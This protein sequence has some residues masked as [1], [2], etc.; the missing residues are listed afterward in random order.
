MTR[1]V[2]R[3]GRRIAE[4]LASEVE[5]H[6]D[7]PLDRLA[8][9]DADRD[10]EASPHGTFAYEVTRDGDP[11]GEVYLHEDRIRL[12]LW[13]RL[14]AARAAAEEAGLRTRP[15]AVDPPRLVVFVENG[16]EVKRTLPVL[17]AVAAGNRF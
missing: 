6:E 14:D 3:D 15:K 2:L 13:T 8:V 5:G 9:G 16:A 1:D 11:V 4:L 7:P 10:A 12:E 17:R